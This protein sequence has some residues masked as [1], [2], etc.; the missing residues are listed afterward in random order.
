MSYYSL[1]VVAHDE[2]GN[3]AKDKA[4]GKKIEKAILKFSTGSGPGD[5]VAHYSMSTMKVVASFDS[6]KESPLVLVSEGWGSYSVG[7]Q[8]LPSYLV[9]CLKKKTREITEN[10]PSS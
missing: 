4:L 6:N 9:K 3:L 5:I 1:I 7:K 2:L 10:T 8:E